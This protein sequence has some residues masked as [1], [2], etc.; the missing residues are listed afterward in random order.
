MSNTPRCTDTTPGELLAA[1][2]M[3]LLTPEEQAQ[4]ETHLSDCPACQEDLYEAAPMMTTLHADPGIVASRLAAEGAV[5][6][7]S[8][9]SL[10]DRLRAR[11]GFLRPGVSWGVVWKPL[12]PVAVAAAALVVV[13]L[14]DRADS[15]WQELARLEPIPY[16]QLETRAEATNQ[17]VARF[18]SGMTL[19]LDK[20]Y[21]MAAERLAESFRMQECRPSSDI[22]D[23]AAL[24]AGLSFL[25]G[26]AADSAAVYLGHALESPHRVITDRSRWYLAQSCLLQNEPDGAMRSLAS[27]AADSPGYKRQAAE[28]LAEIRRRIEER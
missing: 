23:Q 14:P 16:V 10:L 1:Y 6:R 19:Y 2:E 11:P 8:P 22:R 5:R 28:Q 27:L 21:T 15:P 4:F 7:T 9:E 12:V 20:D 25:L 17:A 26:G 3:G 13:F 18:R 24:Y